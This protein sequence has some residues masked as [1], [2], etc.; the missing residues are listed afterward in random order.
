MRVAAF[1]N[2]GILNKWHNEKESNPSGGSHLHSRTDWCE[3]IHLWEADSLTVHRL[4]DHD[5]GAGLALGPRRRRGVGRFGL[6]KQRRRQI[7]SKG[8]VNPEAGAAVTLTC[9][10]NLGLNSLAFGLRVDFLTCLQV[11]GDKVPV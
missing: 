10:L 6:I 4:L 2:L 3:R 11:D 8:Q 5:G 1:I 9:V 7:K